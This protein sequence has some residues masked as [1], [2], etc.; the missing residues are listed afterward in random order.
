MVPRISE[1][2]PGCDCYD[3]ARS[4]IFESIS[5]EHCRDRECEARPLSR[6]LGQLRRRE[7]CA[8]SA[9]A[10]SLQKSAKGNRVAAIVRRSIPRQGEQSVTSAKQAQADR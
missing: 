4:R 7:S 3:L 8:R 5:R 2:L 10:L 1:K 6:Q 9:A